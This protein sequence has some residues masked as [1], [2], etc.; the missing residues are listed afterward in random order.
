MSL[1]GSLHS[2]LGFCLERIV[3]RH[4][5][6]K[7]RQDFGEIAHLLDTVLMQPAGE[8]PI[9][10]L[11]AHL[12]NLRLGKRDRRVAMRNHSEPKARA[13][14]AAIIGIP[15]EMAHRPDMDR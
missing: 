12:P 13:H 9:E 5:A 14:L 4:A 11:A 7:R 6:I 3:E 15:N 8:F 10:I 2:L 1:M